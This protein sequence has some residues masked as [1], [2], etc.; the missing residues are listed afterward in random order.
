MRRRP[1]C[2]N[3]V[4]RRVGASVDAWWAMDWRWIDGLAHMTRT[5]DACALVSAAASPDLRMRQHAA[6]VSTML[7][8]DQSAIAMGHDGT[9]AP[10]L[11]QPAQG[12][13]LSRATRDGI[14]VLAAA[15]CRVGVDIEAIEAGREPAWNVLSAQER[16]ALQALPEASLAEAFAQVWSAKE[17]YLKALGIGLRQE[18]SGFSVRCEGKHFRITDPQRPGQTCLGFLSTH[19]SGIRKYVLAGALLPAG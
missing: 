5:H 4:R 6:L 12:L 8:L 16:D 19:A 3:V 2:V 1:G 17:A 10:V 11:L 15:S 14:A 13:S 18:P 7:G 9:G